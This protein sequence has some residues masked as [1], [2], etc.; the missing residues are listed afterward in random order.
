VHAAF[1]NHD[2]IDYAVAQS[3]KPEYFKLSRF[4]RWWITMRAYFASNLHYHLLIVLPPVV[5]GLLYVWM[6]SSGPNS[7]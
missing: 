6:P 7:P 2:D 4:D 5:V 3:Q 1:E